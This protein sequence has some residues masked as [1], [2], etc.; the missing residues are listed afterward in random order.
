MPPGPLLALL[1]GIEGDDDGTLRLSGQHVNWTTNCLYV[2]AQTRAGIFARITPREVAGPR[3]LD[4]YRSL[5]HCSQ[6]EQEIHF[7]RELG[8]PNIVQ[9]VPSPPALQRLSAVVRATTLCSATL[10][11]VHSTHAE[12]S[13]CTTPASLRAV[14]DLLLNTVC[15]LHSREVTHRRIAPRH[16]L[17]ER[18]EDP[19]WWRT[20]RLS[21]FRE[22]VHFGSCAVV[23]Q[24]AESRFR[25]PDMCSR[26][27]YS[28]LVDV[29]AAAATCLAA[30]A[31]KQTDSEF[32]AALRVYGNGRTA[33]WL[34]DL[35]AADKG[36][37]I[38]LRQALAPQVHRRKSA[39]CVHQLLGSCDDAE[40]ATDERKGRKRS[41]PRA[42]PEDSGPCA[43]PWEKLAH[44]ARRAKTPLQ[45]GAAIRKEL[46]RAGAFSADTIRTAALELEAEKD[47]CA[48]VG[49]EGNA[50]CAAAI[51]ARLGPGEAGPLL[52]VTAPAPTA[53]AARETRRLQQEL[54]IAPSPGSPAPA[55]ACQP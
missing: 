38:S 52:G 2:R 20:I 11:E 33:A 48:R 17:I 24:P 26:I 15:F 28:E 22:A 45:D 53:V 37:D 32:K 30:R 4:R 49:T 18:H 43:T 46:E 31:V 12:A 47:S 39:A 9:V 55:D 54:G 3:K 21:G 14:F 36:L 8:H 50:A 29:W 6:A 16:V 5:Y 7:L 51:L 42:A 44:C 1:D 10:H 27:S 13:K 34:N 40:M 19:E 23:G 35:R 41:R 25:S